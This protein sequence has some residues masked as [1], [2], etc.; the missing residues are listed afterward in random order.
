M[1]VPVDYVSCGVGVCCDYV[2]DWRVYYWKPEDT[3][4]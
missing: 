1:S 2:V 4:Q 3:I